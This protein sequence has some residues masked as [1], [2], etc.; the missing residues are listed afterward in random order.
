MSTRPDPLAS[1][2]SALAKAN[3]D[4]PSS[5]ANGAGAPSAAKAPQAKP[6]IAKPTPNV[7]N[8]L[9]A[10]QDN[11]NQFVASLP[12][13][14]QGGKVPADGPYNLKEGET[15][16]PADKTGRNSEYRKVYINRKTKTTDAKPQTRQEGG[17]K[18]A[19]GEK[20]PGKK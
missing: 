20:H 3:K 12:K 5:M 16:V 18:P 19:Q 8:E 6:A 17:N 14:H 2:K 10:K 7:G 4:F 9:K 1:A 15:V 11:V 13:M